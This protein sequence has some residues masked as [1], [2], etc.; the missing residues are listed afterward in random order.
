MKAQPS[1]GRIRTLIWPIASHELNKFLPM[2]A[3][4]FLIAANYNILKIVKDSTLVPIIGAEVIPFIKVWMMLPMAVLITS[5]FTLLVKKYD[6]KKAFYITILSFL[7]YFFVFVFLIYPNRDYFDFNLGSEYVLEFLPKSAGNF[8][9]MLKNWHVCL[10]YVMCEIWGTMV[11]FVLFWGFANTFINLQ[12]AKRFYPLMGLAGNSSGIFVPFFFSWASKVSLF[13]ESLFS[14]A[15]EQTLGAITLGVLASGFLSIGIYSYLN[16]NMNKNFNTQ[17]NNVTPFS[18]KIKKKNKSSF[19]SSLK[20]V[21]KMPYVRN[22]TVIVLSYNILINL[23][24]VIWKD[25]I[26]NLYPDSIEYGLY[27]GKVMMITGILATISDFFLCSNLIRKF[28]WT[29]TAMVTP[30]IMAVTSICFFGFLLAADSVEPYL[31]HVFGIGPIVLT[32]FFGSMQNALARSSKYSLF[33]AT[34]EMAFIPLDPQCR[35]QSKAAIDGVCSRLGK[36]GGSLFYQFLLLGV[37]GGGDLVACVPYVAVMVVILL[38]VW[39]R[40]VKQLGKRFNE[41][42]SENIKSTNIRSIEEKETL[43]PK[44]AG[45]WSADKR[46]ADR[47]R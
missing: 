46:L 39:G 28:G 11:L 40:S 37:V 21:L 44:K 35:V 2:V 47:C 43:Q 45:G 33:D 10:F 23:T 31:L 26:R 8:A 22:L 13:P 25:Q 27:F 5:M 32:S 41:L 19:F 1:F 4:I 29:A 20:V 12:E 3:M 42:T 7:V 34:K 17:K 30:V 38:S 36:S 24:E 15:W 6:E 16:S 14:S 18:S 9:V